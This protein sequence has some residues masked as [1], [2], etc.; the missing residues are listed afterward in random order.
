MKI[1]N[2]K[3]ISVYIRFVINFRL[4]HRVLFIYL[5]FFFENKVRLNRFDLKNLY[6][7]KQIFY[8]NEEICYCFMITEIALVIFLYLLCILSLALEVTSHHTSCE[9]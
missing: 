4:F 1:L 9:L 6:K 2:K 8:V 7:K 5:L 3:K